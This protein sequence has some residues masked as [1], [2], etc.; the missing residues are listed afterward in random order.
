MI[1]FWTFRF[2]AKHSFFKKTVKDANNFKNILLTLA[3]RHQLALAYHMGM[4]DLFKP[5]VEVGRMSTV[6]LDILDPSVKDFVRSKFSNVTA[7]ALTKTAFLHGT[8]Y[9]QGMFLSYGSTGGLPDFGKIIHILIVANNPLFVVEPYT[10]WYVEHFRCFE[11]CKNPS[12]K[13]L[14]VQ[15]EELNDY[16]PL[17]AYMVQE[18]LLIS[19]RAFL[20]N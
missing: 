15:P 3:S 17:F 10:S 5:A 2:E 6:S 12:A 7:V 9:T 1:D 13:V 11:V 8:Q 18:K 19:P 20:L 16:H 4:P 14:V